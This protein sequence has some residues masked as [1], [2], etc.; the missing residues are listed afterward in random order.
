ML[1]EKG[2]RV[3]L[4]DTAN[5]LDSSPDGFRFV[6]YV[7]VRG[8][9]FLGKRLGKYFEL[10]F[11]I[12][13]LR[14]IWYRFR[15]DLVN[16]QWVDDRA[17]FCAKANLRPLVLSC[18]GSDINNVFWDEYE[19]VLDPDRLRHALSKANYITAD[20]LEVL[21]RCELLVGRKLV[22]NLYFF[23]IDTQQFARP[24]DKEAK[25]L[26]E[27]LGIPMN[28]RVILSS[29]RLHPMMGQFHIL[30]AF[31]QAISDPNMPEA[32][33]VFKKYLSISPEFEKE[34]ALRVQEL[35]VAHKVYWLEESSYAEVPIQ[36]AMADIVVNYPEQDAFPVSL[37][38][39]TASKRAV[40]SA[41]LPAYE[42]LF[43]DAI[44]TVPPGQPV[45]LSRAIKS[46]LVEEPQQ[47]KARVEKAFVK[48]TNLGD[49][50]K[51]RDQLLEAFECL[52]SREKAAGLA[53]D[54]T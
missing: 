29:R 49:Q 12:A 5:P 9:R 34:L 16:V 21:D 44:L 52:I 38:E 30:Q 25:A 31:A 15:P 18:W 27:K 51:N 54:P 35:G 26:R 10:A 17:W 22:T 14:Y 37:F 42:G 11:R 20:S 41:N 39:A 46:C 47:R 40:I 1:L 8:L 50:K 48:S 6:R 43:D 28:C 3:T 53:S 7:P 24:Y 32:V 19:N 45:S 33:L 2:C 13:Q 36:Y 4:L 23:G